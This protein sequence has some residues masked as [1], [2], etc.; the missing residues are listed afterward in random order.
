MD[1]EKVPVSKQ[2]LLALVLGQSCPILAQQLFLLKGRRVLSSPC[3]GLTK[4]PCQPW[5]AF[6][7]RLLPLPGFS[8]GFWK[9][10]WGLA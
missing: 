5:I 6:L 2:V 10:I 4:E 3:F 8:E 9:A 7:Q 1:C